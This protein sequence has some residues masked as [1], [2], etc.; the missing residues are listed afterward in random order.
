MRFTS[1]IHYDRPKAMLL[2]KLELQISWDAHDTY[3]EC[4]SILKEGQ[5]KFKAAS[6]ILSLTN[7]H[8]KNYGPNTSTSIVF[9]LIQDFIGYINFQLVTTNPMQCIK[10]LRGI[11]MV[12]FIDPIHRDVQ[13][14]IQ[15]FTHNMHT[16]LCKHPDVYLVG[17]AF[18]Q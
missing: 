10:Y 9:N 6:Y 3:N 7:S 17:S 15:T 12:P 2:Y 16:L 11:Y 4:L 14:A 18:I 8:K 13:L 1:N 5:Q